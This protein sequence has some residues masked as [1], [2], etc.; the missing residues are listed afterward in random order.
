MLIPSKE[1]RM[2]FSSSTVNSFG[3][4]KR[5]EGRREMGGEIQ[6]NVWFG[7]ADKGNVHEGEAYLKPE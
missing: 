7:I 3:E 5:G 2:I 4:L 1:E 6:R